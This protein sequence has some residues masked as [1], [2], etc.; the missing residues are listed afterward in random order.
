[1]NDEYLWNKT[2][3]DP[4]IEKLEKVLAVFRYR[5]T[6]PPPIRQIVAELETPRRFRLS[7]AFAFA[8]LAIA[9]ALVAAVWLRISNDNFKSENAREIV[10]VQQSADAPETLPAVI[11]PKP[12]TR[13]PDVPDR[14]SGTRRRTITRAGTAS[15]HRPK[16]KDSAPKDSVATLTKEERFAYR[17]LMLALSITGSKLKIVQDAIDGTQAGVDTETKNQR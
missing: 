14:P 7:F 8:S 6:T 15:Y 10:F 17:Q 3:T 9:A 5:E 2:G 12:P 13:N 1:M 11:Q 16:T 4:E